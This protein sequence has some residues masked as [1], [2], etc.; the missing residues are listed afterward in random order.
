MSSPDYRVLTETHLARL[1]LATIQPEQ[2]QLDRRERLLGSWTQENVVT[3]PVDRLR[4]DALYR[5]QHPFSGLLSYLTPL[6]A[7]DQHGTAQF[8]QDIPVRSRDGGSLDPAH[9]FEV[10]SPAVTTIWQGF[11]VTRDIM[12]RPVW[13]QSQTLFIEPSGVRK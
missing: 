12:A 2:E 13:R 3:R 11:Q 5:R 7:Q 8:R 9:D 4:P 1:G 6:S 10:V